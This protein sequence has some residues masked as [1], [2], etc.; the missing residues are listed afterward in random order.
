VLAF[1]EPVEWVAPGPV[2]RYVRACRVRLAR[3][4][5]RVACKPVVKRRVWTATSRFRERTVPPLRGSSPNCT[6]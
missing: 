2:E 1:P 5:R 6:P 4:L 3:R